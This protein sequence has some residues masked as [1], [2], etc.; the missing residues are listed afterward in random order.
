MPGSVS[1][2]RKKIASKRWPPSSRMSLVWASFTEALAHD[3]ELVRKDGRVEAL[4]PDLAVDRL[5]E[6]LGD[7]VGRDGRGEPTVERLHKAVVLDFDGAADDGERAEVLV[8]AL[9]ADAAAVGM[10]EQ[11]LVGDEPAE[12]FKEAE[13]TLKSQ[14][15]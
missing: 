5:H 2:W 12:G 7:L 6:A 8:G 9:D 14:C 11:L 1:V 13:E 4:A 15:L 3:A 10:I